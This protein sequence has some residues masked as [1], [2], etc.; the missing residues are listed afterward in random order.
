[1]TSVPAVAG[2]K[3]WDVYLGNKTLHVQAFQRMTGTLLLVYKPLMCCMTDTLFK[4]TVLSRLQQDRFLCVCIL[5]F[6][7]KTIIFVYEL[8]F[9]LL[10]IIISAQILT[11]TCVCVCCLF[12][13]VLSLCA[14]RECVFV[15]QL[16]QQPLCTSVIWVHVFVSCCYSHTHA[17]FFFFFFF[18]SGL[19]ALDQI[20]LGP[21]KK[22]SVMCGDSQRF[23]S[24]QTQWPPMQ[25]GGENQRKRE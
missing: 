23:L 5:Y 4:K 7:P 20:R 25:A 12:V 16:Q 9:F 17:A 10:T 22:I 11:Q 18:C 15:K 19:W 8:I 3:G 14:A 13:L 24:P 6:G 21:K 2:G 1:M